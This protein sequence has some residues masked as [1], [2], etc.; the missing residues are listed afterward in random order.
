[1]GKFERGE[2]EKLEIDVVNLLNEGEVQT[3]HTC[4]QRVLERIRGEF[5]VRIAVFIGRTYNEPGNIKLF[6]ADG[7]VAYIELKF[8]E[9]GKGTRANLGQN[10]LTEFG[11][12][13]GEGIVSWQKFREKKN[14]DGEVLKRLNKYSYYDEVKLPK[15]RGGEKERKAR[16]L[17]EL[18]KPKPGED[19]ELAVRR[20]MSSQDYKLRQVAEI[21]NEI[22]ELARVDKLEYIKYLQSLRQNSESI[23]KF[24]ILILLGLHKEDILREAFR[25]F[26]QLIK[27]L[28][29][30]LFVYKTYY[31]RRRD[32]EVCSEDLTTLIGKLLKS[33]DFRIIFP[34]NET[35]CVIEY[36][37]PDSG[38]WKKLLRIVFHWK[39]VF[40]GIATP[41]LNIFDEGE[42]KEICFSTR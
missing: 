36:R 14:F 38:A 3:P 39:N 31:V 7:R 32:C 37:D 35:N 15:Y 30:G 33:N 18:L 42:L 13:E 5:N 8:V 2:A 9:R 41:C 11:L 27:S 26:N 16:Y 1:M 29:E 24:T 4:A 17:R 34:Q 21:V 23:R 12:F 6:L 20:A 40:Q 19:I 22:L 10:A 28:E 25:R